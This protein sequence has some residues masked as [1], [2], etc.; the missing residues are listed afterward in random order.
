M[1]PTTELFPHQAAAV[2]KLRDLRVGALLMEMGTGKSR[3]AIELS[4][5]KMRRG[6][7]KRVIWFCPV[8]AKDEIA[9]EIRKHLPD[10]SIHV[11]DDKVRRDTVPQ[12]DWHIV[13]IESLSSSARVAEAATKIAEYAVVIL[14]EAH[15]I[16]NARCIRS[17]RLEAIGRLAAYRYILSGTL[18]TNSMID[19]YSPFHWLSP[20]VMGYSSFLHFAH[21]HL[22]YKK[23]KHTGR[24]YVS[25][26]KDSSKIAAKIAPYT[27]QVRKEECQDLPEKTFR[28]SWYEMPPAMEKKYNDLKHFYLVEQQEATFDPTSISMSIFRLFVS[29]QRC[30]SG[31]WRDE[32]GE[33]HRLY[34]KPLDN[35]RIRLLLEE[36]EG[37]DPDRKIV[38]WCKYVFE[39]DDILAALSA[40]LPNEKVVTLTGRDRPATR[41]ESIAAFRVDARFIVATSQ[42]GGQSIDLTAAHY[43][44]YYSYTF[45]HWQAVQSQDRLHRY[46]Q[47]MPVTYVDIICN[48]SIDNRI[49][50]ALS[51]KQDLA[52]YFRKKVDEIRNEKE[53]SAAM[54]KLA[55]L[56]KEI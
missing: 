34:P 18:I 35:P 19:T 30:V 8:S 43:A 41:S 29:L 36:I 3:T 12:A 56:V 54:I 16:K 28:A 42:I 48:G 1:R 55:A 37:I 32:D 50:A 23:D 25:G 33:Q 9:S 31:Y 17:R 45:S 53:K 22:I 24:N 10:A 47:T 5:I 52:E 14:D 40:E 44:I 15:L 6:R 39:V 38:I 51:G 2:A 26:F 7:A 4:L 11:F 21:Y 49:R 20:K 46:G 27:Y 13:G